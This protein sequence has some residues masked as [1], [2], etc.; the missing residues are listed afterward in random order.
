MGTSQSGTESDKYWI[1]I[2]SKSIHKKRGHGKL[3]IHTNKLYLKGTSKTTTKNHKSWQQH[4]LSTNL[5]GEGGMALSQWPHWT[6][7]TCEFSVFSFCTRIWTPL[8]HPIITD[9]RPSARWR[10]MT[11]PRGMATNKIIPF[12]KR[13]EKVDT[14]TENLLTGRINYTYNG[15][16][17]SLC[18]RYK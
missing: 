12:A 10:A 1:F 11:A 6:P 18:Y 8:M 16:S 4:I 5:G 17:R 3:L 13:K 15:H 9:N 2:N 7:S 14:D